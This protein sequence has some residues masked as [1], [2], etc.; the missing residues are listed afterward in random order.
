[1]AVDQ[2]CYRFSVRRSSPEIFMVKFWRTPEIAPNFELGWVNVSACNLLLVN[3]SSPISCRTQQ[4]LPVIKFVSHLRHCNRF[5]RYSRSKSK[6]VQNWTNFRFFGPPKFFWASQIS[7]VQVAQNLYISDYVHLMARHVAK[8][9]GG[10]PFTP[11]ATGMDMSNLKPIL[12]PFWK[13]IV[14]GTQ[15]PL[16]GCTDKTWSFSSA[17]ENLG[18]QLPLGAEIWSSEK[19]HLGGCDSTSRSLHLAE[20]SSRN[21]FH[22]MLEELR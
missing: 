14:R 22:R 1:M 3:Q 19:D 17:G 16:G 15:S 10:T 11:K 20:Q 9:H 21:F 7:E 6:V 13:K 4:E 18:A 8:F 12:D 5:L 2:V